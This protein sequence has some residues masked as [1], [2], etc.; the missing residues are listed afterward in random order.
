MSHGLVKPVTLL[1]QALDLTIV[2][3]KGHFGHA[4]IQLKYAP[5]LI[6]S[7]AGHH[8]RDV[9]MVLDSSFGQGECA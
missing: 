6:K 8:F 9:T 5:I 2:G 4:H 1:D 7:Q 3:A